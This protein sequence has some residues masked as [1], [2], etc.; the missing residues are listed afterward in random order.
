VSIVPPGQPH[1]GR[2]LAGWIAADA[3]Q[4]A[5]ACNISQYETFHT[6]WVSYSDDGGST[7]TPQLAYDAGVGHDASTPFVAYTTDVAG[8]PYFS[9]ATNGNAN[10]ATCFAES[11]AGTLQ[12]DP[13]CEDDMYV[14]WSKDT[15]ATWD[16]GGGTI[17]GSAAAAYRVNPASETGTHW[18]PAIAANQPGQVEVAYLRTPF[19]QPTGP[20][21]KADPGACSGKQS[22]PD[23][24]PCPWDLYTA[25]S[26]DLT[27]APDKATWTI[28]DATPTTPMHIGDICNLGIACVGTAGS[29]RSLLDFIQMS[30]DPTTGCGHVAYADDNVAK[31][32]RAANQ[33]AGCFDTLGTDVPQAPATALLLP[34]GVGALAVTA[35]AHRRRRV[36]ARG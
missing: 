11:D 2:I 15:G 34:L 5:A 9:F 20:T 26:S 19:I 12:S 27:Q 16:G 25:Q 3:P 21:G 28:T 13:T 32:L 36:G 10:P 17:P 31:K 6:L 8:N 24:G 18:F 4:D 29:S 7:W 35:W 22:P 23:V 14:V 33:T 30:I 1:A